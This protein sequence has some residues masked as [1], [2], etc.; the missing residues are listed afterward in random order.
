MKQATPVLLALVIS[1]SVSAHQPPMWVSSGWNASK[2]QAA[3]PNIAESRVLGEVV[4]I[5]QNANRIVVKTDL[6]NRVT[7]LLDE[8]TD[9]FRVPPGEVSMEKAIRITRGEI[10]PG[11][12]VYAR[13]KLSEDRR[14]LP[15]QKMIVMLK[16]DIEK[17]QERRRD[18]WDRRGISGVITA[19]DPK[20]REI[21]LQVRGREG[22][23]TTIITTTDAVKFRRYAAD[24]VQFGEALTSSFTELKTGD[25]VCALGEKNSDGSRFEAE[26]V[27]FGSFRT[28]TGTVTAIDGSSGEISIST[29]GKKQA[30]AVLVRKDSTLRRITPQVAQMIARVAQG[31]RGAGAVSG[32]DELQR[33]L[34]RLPSP[35]LSEIKPGDMITVTSTI[36]ADPLRVTAITLITGMDAVLS[37]IQNSATKRNSPGLDLG[38]PAGLLDSG[39]VRP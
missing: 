25:E 3:D 38:L 13:G 34:D 6:G 10:N 35:S 17:N 33:A 31:S 23:K 29:L 28:V 37:A 4:E 30:L 32:G 9:Y 8:K 26:Q 15:A 18:E 24:S 14:S 36:G 22:V 2:L 12:K 7:I 39:I 20:A 5:D 11:D 27:V 16:G 1:C 19:F 21:T